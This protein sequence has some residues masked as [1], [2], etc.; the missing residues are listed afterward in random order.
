MKTLYI[1]CNMGAAGDMLMAALLEIC[2]DKASFLKKM[3]ELGLPGV[4]VSRYDTEKCGIKGTGISV[5]IYGTE[6][7][8]AHAGHAH[9]HSHE[10]HSHT[11]DDH[12]HTHDGHAHTHSHD[13]HH[14]D[15]EHKPTHHH[16]AG[17][18]DISNIIGNLPL[19]EEVKANALA[20][21][22]IIAEA[23]S[24]VH[25]V[26]VD[27]IHF[28]EVGDLDAIADIVGVCLLVEMLSPDRI[29]VSPIHVGSGHVK[30][31]HGVLPVPAPATAYILKG[32][33]FYSGKIRGE[34]LTPT[35]AALLKHFAGEFSEMPVMEVAAIGYG[36]GK[37]DFEA[38]NCV[39]VYL[40]ETQDE[41]TLRDKIVELSCNLDDMIPEAIG[42][43][44][45]LLMSHG[46]LDVFTAPIYMKKNRPG[47]LLVCL[48]KEKQVQEMA[49]L[50]LK[51]TST[52]GVRVTEHDRYKL[53]GEMD[54]VET[55]YGE[56]RI[57]TSSG[58]GIAK[59]KPEYED[60]VKCAEKHGVPFEEVRQAAFKKMNDQ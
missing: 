7:G 5:K 35:G 55:P 21:Y 54:S 9:T 36:M 20:T 44:T 31:A 28:H 29:I 1:E 49:I 50:M 56:I 12:H 42:Y 17:M 30:A 46:A 26:P 48:C 13:E 15:Q 19:S 40:G 53:K 59:A 45:Q 41:G 22:A 10:E 37:K 32:V 34:L 27:K 38:A 25:G 14:H 47:C 57:K 18:K 33:P 8:E 60:V 6:E 3:N 24:S 51:N 43:A 39:R 52:R 4:Q 11:H 2:P 16:H 23:E 58:Y